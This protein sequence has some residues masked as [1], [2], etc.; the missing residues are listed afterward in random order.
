MLHHPNA[1]VATFQNEDQ[2]RAFHLT[3][4]G[5]IIEVTRESRG[6][7][8]SPPATVAAMQ[9]STPEVAA[10]VGHGPRTGYLVLVDESIEA[11]YCR[12]ALTKVADDLDKRA[13]R[14][15]DKASIGSGSGKTRALDTAAYNEAKARTLRGYAERFEGIRMRAVEQINEAL[16]L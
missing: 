8:W 7:A 13:D 12:E 4:S 16:G 14:S 11:V 1:I 3:Q 2:T 15:R 5:E 9:S 6:A 10:I